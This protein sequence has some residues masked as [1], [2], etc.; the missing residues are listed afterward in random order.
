LSGLIWLRR[1]D[2]LLKKEK[3]CNV[4]KGRNIH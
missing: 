3:F 4:Y 2:G 1:C